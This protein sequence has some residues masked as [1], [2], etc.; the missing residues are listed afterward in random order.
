MEL[1][2]AGGRVTVVLGGFMGPGMAD[3]LV[4]GILLVVGLFAGFLAGLFGIGGGTVLVPM[5]LTLFPL[6]GFD[7][8][9]MM[10]IAVSTSLALIV[11][12]ALASTHSHY[13]FG[14]LDFKMLK[15]W[16]PGLVIGILSSAV[17]IHSIPTYVLKLF[18]TGYLLVCFL[19]TLLKQAGEGLNTNGPGPWISGVS[20]FFVGALSTLL[21]TGGGTFTVPIMLYFDYPL[22]KGIAISAITG[23]FIGLIGSIV[24]I[25]GSYQIPDLPNYSLGYVNLLAF[26]AVAPT[27]MLASKYGARFEERLPKHRLNGLYTLF[28]LVAFLTMLYHLLA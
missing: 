10:H 7:H 14:H 28:L 18:F 11:P 3:W 23:L 4:V 2:L 6:F 26:V 21:G 13:Q 16:A 25:L 12:T 1:A 22:K 19:F 20:S 8:G 24:I 5:F 27:A 15:K 9:L 17:V